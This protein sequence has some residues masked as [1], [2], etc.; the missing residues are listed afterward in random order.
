M[1]EFTPIITLP[2]HI[3][4]DTPIIT[5][6]RMQ[7]L[8]VVLVLVCGLA[9]V[10]EVTAQQALL[11]EV[12][13]SARKIAETSQ[14]VPISMSVLT[15]EKIQSI[16]A[17]DFTE[18][19]RIVPS[20]QLGANSPASATLKIRNVGPDF[21]ALAFPAAVAVYVDGVPQAQPGSVFS[22]MLDIQRIEV[23][24]GPQGTLYGKNAPAGLIS[25]YTVNP[26][27]NTFGGYVT[28][29]YSSWDTSNSMAAVDIPLLE[30]KLAMRVAG[31]YARSDGYMDNAIPGVNE[32]NGKDHKG[33]RTKLLWQPSDTV[34]LLFSYYHADL[35]TDDNL[36]GYQGQVPD[37]RGLT[38]YESQ[39]HDFKVFKG[40]PSYSDTKVDD[41]NLNGQWTFNDV[42][43]TLLGQYQ[44]LDIFQQQDNSEWRVVPPP[45]VSRDY[46]EFDPV[47]YSIEL[48]AA[49]E[50][51]DNINYLFGAIYT[52]DDTDTVNFIQSINIDG[53]AKTESEGIY[54]NWTYR[55][56][57]QW[58]SSLGVRYSN[59]DYDASVFG[60]IP[61]LGELNSDYRQSYSDPSYSFKL[62][63]YPM[64][65]VL[66][67]AAIDTAFRSGGLNVLAP[68]A[69]QLS[70]IFTQEPVSGNLLLISEE[71]LAFGQEDSI[72]YE[73]GMKGTF[74][75]QRFR[76]NIAMFYQ[77]YDDHQYRTSPSDSA[78]T[79]V[80]S[81]PLSNLAVN[82][83]DLDVYG[84]ETE[85]DYII[86]DNW[87]LFTTAAYAKPEIQE[88]SKRMC[89]EGEAAPGTLICP[90]EKGE[91]LNDEP[92]F[93]MLSQLGY[94]RGIANTQWEF[95][96]EFTA[97]YYSKPKQ[98]IDTPNIDDWL[99]FDLA[100]GVQDTSGVW[101]AKV[102]SKNITDKTVVQD[103]EIE[104]D[105]ATAA[106]LGYSAI[107]LAPRSV[108]VTVE[109]RF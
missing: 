66:A 74:F 104:E 70:D 60:F 62:R 55:F 36:R 78:V 39:Y 33:T 102:W 84:L 26:A 9:A 92:L 76:W 85:I 57:D 101:S 13:V 64:P 82:V 19:D 49:G 45:E 38:D 96:G 1:G 72:A 2:T 24:N 93:H 30:D 90:G 51:G 88:Y 32:A 94:T 7:K 6:E 59:V 83:E 53:S 20:L 71:Y 107:P 97:E 73:L 67:Y 23:L 3:L 40:I 14:T 103:E 16:N 10:G 44:D 80:L 65:E 63:Y 79:S 41:F 68:L 17:F 75:E 12:V 25:I 46:L 50:I 61:G 29:S 31:M 87:S 8:S 27:M 56:N 89:E 4:P 69:G 35:T 106:L 100:L 48:Q 18:I 109:Y 21:F 37:D 22:T 58:D 99:I 54:T 86:A 11:E 105:V 98:V 91:P 108:G 95:F 28:S 52:N 34:E 81:G 5:G 43:F 47:A 42:H 15:E 77:S